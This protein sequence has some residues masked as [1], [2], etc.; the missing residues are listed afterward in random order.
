[1][2]LDPRRRRCRG[3][4]TVHGGESGE[5]LDLNFAGICISAF[6]CKRP[7]K[8]RG[9]ERWWYTGTGGTDGDGVI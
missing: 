7:R 2:R 8:R 9:E 5:F 3:E 6:A 1:M 4:A